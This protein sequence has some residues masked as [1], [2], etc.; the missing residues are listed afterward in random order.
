MTRN[1]KITA[2]LIVAT[3]A[4]VGCTKDK[5]SQTENKDTQRSAKVV[6]VSMP[7]PA[8]DKSLDVTTPKVT[9]PVSY[10]DGEA[11]FQAGKYVE[12]TNVF[13]QYTVEKPNNPWGHFMLGLSESKVGDTEKAEKAFEAA[14]KID[15]DHLKSLLNLSRMLIDQKRFD[16]AIVTLAHAG[17]INPASPEVHRLLGR[18]YTGQHKTDDAIVSYR[19]AIALDPTDAWSMNNLGLILIQKGRPSEATPLL[20]KAV[21]LQKNAPTFHNNLGMALEQTARFKAAA[22]EYKDALASDP[23]NAKAKSNLARIE[24]VKVGSEESFDREAE[25]KR[26]VEVKQTAT[27]SA[28]VAQ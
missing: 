10:A 9:G 11:L 20:A 1:G 2:T 6:T 3:I 17:E 28:T 23:N 26:A 16:D 24:A 5:T 25:A 8:A 4:A 21:E 7:T 27:E 18:T 12:A 15:P 22:S 14:L 19:R 13:E